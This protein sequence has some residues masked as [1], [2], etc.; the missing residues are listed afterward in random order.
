[1]AERLRSDIAQTLVNGIAPDATE[2]GVYEGPDTLSPQ[3]VRVVYDV[4]DGWPVYEA[5][6]FAD[7]VD[8]P[9]NEAK[10]IQPVPIDLDLNARIQ[11]FGVFLDSRGSTTSGQ[12]RVKYQ[13]VVN[14]LSPK[15]LAYARTKLTEA[16]NL[17]FLRP[18]QDTTGSI[19]DVNWIRSLH[20]QWVSPREGVQIECLNLFDGQV[21]LS[22]RA[23]ILYTP[24]GTPPP[25]L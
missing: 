20:G 9:A 7:S 18:Y 19:G 10:N 24:P 17:A 25:S 6:Y 15:T 3:S 12:A 1:M 4:S 8:I 11:A 13:R 21:T 5:E 22:I 23:E 14:P 2:D 16:D